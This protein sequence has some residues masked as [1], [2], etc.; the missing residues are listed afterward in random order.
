MRTFAYLACG[1]SDPEDGVGPAACAA[2]RSPEPPTVSELGSI[3][4]PPAGAV[5]NRGMLRLSGDTGGS[6]SLSTL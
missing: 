4:E 3:E 1:V 5:P 6:Y 2:K